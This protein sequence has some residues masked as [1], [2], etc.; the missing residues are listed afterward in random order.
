[1][2]PTSPFVL[3]LLSLL[4]QLAAAAP[5]AADETINP[6]PRATRPRTLQVW[7]FAQDAE[8][9]SSENQCR[10]TA[11]DG[12]LRAVSLGNDPYF[13][14][15]VELP[16][17]QTVVQLRVRSE[18][19]GRGSVFWTTDQHPQRGEDKRAD[20]DLPADGQ[21]L[22]TQSRFTAPGTLT[23]LRIDPGTRP[24]TV[25]IDSI[26][27]IH[28]EVHPL[29]SSQV[30]QQTDRIDFTVRNESDVDTSFTTAGQRYTLAGGQ[31][32]TLTRTAS[33]NAPLQPITLRL[34]CADWP[35]LERAAWLLRDADTKNDPLWIRQPLGQTTLSVARNGS[36]ALIHKTG[37]LV[38]AIGPLATVDG[39]QVPLQSIQEGNVIQLE[40]E[41]LKIHLAVAGYELAIDIQSSQPCEGPIVRVL[42]DLQQ[43]LFA[44]LEYLG[45]NERSSSTLDIETP[46]HIR[47]EPDPLKV[48]MPLM[49]LL[50]D[51]GSV[52]MTWTDMQLQPTYATPNFFDGSDDH[53]MSLKG[54]EIHATLRVAD[55]PLEESIAW[56]VKKNGLPVLP[57]VPR[58]EQQQDALCVV[59]L[60]GPLRTERG[61]GHCVQE[62]LGASPFCRYGFHALAIDGRGAGVPAV[63]D[64]WSARAQWD[65]LLCHRPGSTLAGPAASASTGVDRPPTARRVVSLR[66]QV[67]PRSFRGHGQR[68]L[69]NSRCAV[70]GIRL[71]HG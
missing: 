40:G 39:Q 71:V 63:R 20:F 48:T 54:Q 34:Q 4:A 2:K 3:F 21:W 19:G 11:V 52:A 10:L 44:G 43:G 67:R 14:R 60:R 30:V 33:G 22:V 49:A 9:W 59:A 57:V 45:K 65:H 47:L 17:G 46:E 31:T 16:G 68:R 5:S 1:M 15:K 7:E 70:A 61:W 56:A 35:P 41:G 51:R 64:G 24:G 38:A 36:V 6:I 55:D 37:Q 53:R 42:G 23:D 28:E 13:H 62:A 27:V 12:T 26:R 69:C 18:V 8:G 32:Q 29:T 58:N 25:E 66:R 50:T